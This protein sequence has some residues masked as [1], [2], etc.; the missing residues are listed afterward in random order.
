MIHKKIILTSA[1]MSLCTTLC[2][3]SSSQ[4][5]KPSQE[6]KIGLLRRN[7]LITAL[8]EEYNQNNTMPIHTENLS[9]DKKE[10]ISIILELLNSN[11]ALMKEETDTRLPLGNLEFRRARHGWELNI[12]QYLIKRQSNW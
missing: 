4:E 2:I 3:H 9:I 5:T 6:Q 10:E 7:A 8:F 11:Q 12:Y 1:L